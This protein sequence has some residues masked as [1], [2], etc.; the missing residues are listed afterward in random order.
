MLEEFCL[1]EKSVKNVVVVALSLMCRA[2]RQA[3]RGGPLTGVG[4]L[5]LWV[6]Y[7]CGSLPGVGRLLVWVTYWCGSL[8]GVGRLLVWVAYWCGSLTGPARHDSKISHLTCTYTYLPPSSFNIHS[9][10][11]YSSMHYIQV[12]P[13]KRTPLNPSICPLR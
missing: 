8:T 10:L 6:T 13:A 7:W 11:F 3:G 12:Y 1:H 9:S 5:L 4:R 2:S